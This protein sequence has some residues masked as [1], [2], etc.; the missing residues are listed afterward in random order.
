MAKNANAKLWSLQ[1][2]ELN[3]RW[4]DQPFDLTGPSAPTI[5]AHGAPTSTSVGVRVTVAA[6]DNRTGIVG[7]NVEIS[8]SSL[9]PFTLHGFVNVAQATAGFDITG[10][11]PSTGYFVRLKGK[12]G[13]F[14]GNIGAASNQVSQ[15]T[16]APA[17]NGTWY[18]NWPV[19]N[20]GA[21]QGSSSFHILDPT[22]HQKISEHDVYMF[23]GFNLTPTRCAT[24]V[25]RLQEIHALNLNGRKTRM[26]L[27]IAHQQVHKVE[28]DSHTSPILALI[29]HA[30]KGNPLWFARRVTSGNQIEAP[31]NPVIF[32]LV[33][34][35]R[36]GLLNSLGQTYQIALFKEYKAL[37]N[38]SD[39]AHNV[40]A[41]LDGFFLDDSHFR[42]QTPMKV[43]NGAT[44]VTD[45]DINQNGV[46]ESITDW[47]AGATA[48]CRMWCEGHLDLK[49]ALKSEFGNDFL[50]WTNSSEVGSYYYDGGGQPPLPMNLLQMYG[51]C[52]VTLKENV[53]QFGFGFSKSATQ[54]TYN[55]GGGFFHCS[56]LVHINRLTLLPDNQCAGGR[57]WVV[58]HFPT[59]DRTL[60][61]DDYEM[62]RFV[63]GF[64]L[65]QERCAVSVNRAGLVPISLDELKLELGNPIGTRSLG[66]MNESTAGYTQRTADFSNGVG[67]FFFALF[68]R[69]NGTRTL[70]VV[71]FDTPTIG[72][73][74]PNGDAAVS[75]TLPAPAS[76]K[77]WQRINAATYTH[78]TTGLQM[79]NQSPSVNNGADTGAT[80][81]MRPFTALF[82]QEVNV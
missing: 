57:A 12:D 44:T 70:I 78:P 68:Q 74:Y 72:A 50:C 34:M 31:F 79:T 24:R 64:A 69:A 5:I 77:K 2:G 65:I 33:N 73:I 15:S 37:L 60:T 18:P 26:I 58:I 52:E 51:K 29:N 81:S 54:Y 47:S 46:A 45:I 67:R 4:S 11:T 23:Q 9:G 25:S 32:W 41:E 59:I 27:Y 28:S 6:V 38:A 56:R 82:L 10:L 62:C 8:Q 66:T 30:T 1:I 22:Q 75:C 43:G 76:G 63:A 55:G 80:V 3:R 40:T 20:I 19:G 36:S 14:A 49:A 7:Y 48:G 39:A 21:T 13:S 53:V 42:L 71:R 17:E 16:S 61:Q 35:G